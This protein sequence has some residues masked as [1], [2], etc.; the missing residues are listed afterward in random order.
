MLRQR[1]D[2]TRVRRLA[3]LEREAIEDEEPE[4]RAGPALEALRLRPYRGGPT[5]SLRPSEERYRRTPP[6]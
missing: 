2:R 4:E 1:G 5:G 3:F 6:H